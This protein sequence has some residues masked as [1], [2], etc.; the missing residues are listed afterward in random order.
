[1][2]FWRL[3]LATLRSMCSRSATA[4]ATDWPAQHAYA[5]RLLDLIQKANPT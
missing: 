3:R 2:A 4:R 1:M 5:L